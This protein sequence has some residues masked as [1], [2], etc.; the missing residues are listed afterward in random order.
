[1]SLGSVFLTRCKSLEVIYLL[2]NLKPVVRQG[3]FENELK[4]VMNFCKK[5][6]LFLVKSKY[7]VLPTEKGYSN[8]GVL[9]SDGMTFVYISKDELLANKAA[10]F[11]ITMDHFNLGLTLGY[12]KCC[13]LFF[14]KEYPFI[15]KLDNNY[16]N[17]VLK[18]STGDSFPYQNNIFRISEDFCLLSH[19]PCSL[20]CI[21]SAKI[22]KAYMGFLEEKMPKE[23][24]LLK[25]E[26]KKPVQNI[27]FY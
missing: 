27:S 7:K 24:R 4:E 18:N 22:G 21:E 14:E 23:A 17:S 8:K 13:S 2:N 5:K 6:N 11:E 1:M 15:S 25:N 12:P 16:Q 19:F 9:S 26:L 10:Y 3:F 20:G